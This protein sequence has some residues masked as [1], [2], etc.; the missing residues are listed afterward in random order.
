MESIYTGIVAIGFYLTQGST[1][2]VRLSVLRHFYIRMTFTTELHSSVN[3]LSNRYPHP[4]QHLPPTSHPQS[5]THP[6]TTPFHHSTSTLPPGPFPIPCDTSFRR[7]QTVLRAAR[8]VLAAILARIATRGAGKCA[9]V[10][11]GVCLHQCVVCI[12]P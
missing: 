11:V 3:L 9:R 4:H 8:A 12:L 7:L 10:C 5:T 1:A 2:K 6:T